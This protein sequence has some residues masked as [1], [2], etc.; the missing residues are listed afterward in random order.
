M[1]NVPEMVSG[2]ISWQKIPYENIYGTK[3][4]NEDTH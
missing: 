2:F 4:D 1:R 3:T